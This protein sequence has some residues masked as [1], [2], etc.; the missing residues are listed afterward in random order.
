MSITK[1]IQGDYTLSATGSVTIDSNLIVTGTSTTVSSTDTIIADKVITLNSGEVAA[2]VGADG[3]SG[4]EIDRGSLNTVALRWNEASDKWELSNDGLTY[5]AIQTTAGSSGYLLNV[6]EDTT[7]QLGG[8]LDVNGQTITSAAGG[9]VVITADGA[10]QL[11]L[12]KVIS[13]QDQGSAPTPTSGYNKLYSATPTGGGTGLH[14][15]NTT[16]NDELISRS[17]ALVYSL[18]L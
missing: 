17:R 10:G 5:S 3:Y 9:D 8:S 18:M 2:G 11:K 16:T 6:V 1:R 7:P 14:F 4:I 13:V 12:D 15:V